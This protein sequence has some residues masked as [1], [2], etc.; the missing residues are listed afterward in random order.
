VPY[1][2]DIDYP[3][4]TPIEPFVVTILDKPYLVKV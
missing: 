1:V 2:G 3:E 4:D